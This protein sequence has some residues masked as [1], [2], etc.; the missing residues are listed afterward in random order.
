M[1]EPKNF[2]KNRDQ[3]S[4]SKFLTSQ[5]LCILSMVI[6]C[7]FWNFA[8]AQSNHTSNDKTKAKPIEESKAEFINGAGA[9]F[10]YPLYAKWFQDFKKSH[11]GV[12]INY[13]AIGSG[14]GI[15][16]LLAGT[17]DFGA[18]DA[19]MKDK[20]L[21]KTKRSILHFPT[22]AGAVVVSYNFPDRKWN[23][24]V[25]LSGEILADIFLGKIKTWNDPAIKSLNPTLDLP[26]YAIAVIY[27]SDSSGTTHVF[28]DYLSRV[29][30][31]WKSTVGVSKSPRW[32]KG[33][34]AKGNMGV[35]GLMK[36][37][38]GAITY[39][40]STYSEQSQLPTAAI[41]N[42]S[43]KFIVPSVS[44][45]KAAMSATASVIPSDFR[46]SIV[47]SPGDQS[48]PIV[49]LTY[50][51]FYADMESGK[52]KTMRE[53]LEWSYSQGQLSAETL[54]YAPLS[55]ELLKSVIKRIP[56]LGLSAA[57]QRS[58]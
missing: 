17:I 14:A 19:P 3:R 52:A 10:P 28:T 23:E 13:Q 55:A 29:S 2:L 53:F 38:R 4:L 37:T 5:K 24:P 15:N 43:G 11:P 54:H 47:D 12:D 7:G 27:R 42:K 39:L 21:A 26:H 1:V 6:A 30:S 25:K 58:Q 44:A 9:T 20:E 46:V 31:E 48:Y 41:K 45:V 36:H 57:P 51:L 32:P 56:Q 49:S 34:G 40:E 16:Q 50:L 35:A 22:V 18:T 8:V 33:I